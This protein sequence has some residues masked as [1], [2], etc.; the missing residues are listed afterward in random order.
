VTLGIGHGKDLSHTHRNHLISHIQ[1]GLKHHAFAQPWPQAGGHLHQN[2]QIFHVG[3][4]Q[5]R[6]SR[7]HGIALLHKLLQDHAVKGCQTPGIPQL[8]IDGLDLGAGGHDRILGLVDLNSGCVEIATTLHTPVASAGKTL[9]RI[10]KHLIEQ[11]RYTHAPR[12]G[13]RLG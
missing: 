2:L 5:Q 6:L 7:L 11:I 13:L 9:H 10:R 1:L 8:G 12:G 3:K 4:H